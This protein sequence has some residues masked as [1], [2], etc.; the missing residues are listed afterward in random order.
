MSL[1]VIS[2]DIAK[3]KQRGKVAKLL[4]GY[5]VRMQYSVFECELEE[6]KFLELYSKMKQISLE[7][8]TDSVRFYKLCKNCERDIKTIGT[9]E[10]KRMILEEKTIVI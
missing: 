4:E 9:V 1:Y 3:D 10:K 7:I 2:Y 6:Q 5:G 8:G